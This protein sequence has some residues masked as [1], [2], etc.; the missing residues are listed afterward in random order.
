MDKGVKGIKNPET[1]KDCAVKEGIK[2]TTTFSLGS[3]L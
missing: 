2:I 3:P 1:P